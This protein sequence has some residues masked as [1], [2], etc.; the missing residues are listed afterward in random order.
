M[1]TTE[2]YNSP[3]PPLELDLGNLHLD[4]PSP[5]SLASLSAS[6]Q[7]I[8]A[9][10]D[11]GSIPAGLWQ[12]LRFKIIAKI[13]SFARMALVQKPF[14]IV[15]NA[16]GG[17]IEHGV[18]ALLCALSFVFIMVP[19]LLMWGIVVGLIKLTV[20]SYET[21]RGWFDSF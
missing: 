14:Q 10:E 12:F 3:L 18:T 13:A 4:R 16:C 17:L 2:D 7:E 9:F 1:N 19:F 11:S 5:A 8:P 20:H 6:P 15:V 21:V